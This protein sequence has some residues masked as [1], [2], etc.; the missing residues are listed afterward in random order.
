MLTKLS[1][2]LTTLLLTGLLNINAS[3]GQCTWRPQLYDGFEY[4]TAVPDLIPGTTIHTTPQ[5][6][7]VHSGA[8]SLYMNFVNSL[9]GGSLVYQR[10]IPVCANLPVRVS[11]WVTTT[12]AGAQ[13]NVKFQLLDANGISLYTTDSVP[14]PYAPLWT[15]YISG[16]VTP[17]TSTITFKMFTNT[18]GTAGGNDLSMDD[19]F[20]EQCNRLN[21]GADTTICNTQSVILN[22][23]NAYTSYLWSTGSTMQTITASTTSPGTSAS[24]YAVN[25][26][27]TNGCSYKDTIR[28]TFVPCAGIGELAGDNIIIS[29]NPAS[30]FIT[31]SSGNLFSSIAL[32]NTLGQTIKSFP[33][34]TQLNLSNIPKG[35]YFLRL[36]IH[37]NS[38]LL[39]KIVL[40]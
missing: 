29:P 26:T 8:K 39:R 11:A 21:L 18:P 25:A 3:L 13:C 1:T 27:D 24:D 30:D 12:F 14:A 20:V 28:V 34:A 33:G 22:A 23:G 9:P 17:T 2:L 16:S 7:A 38:N 40:E 35:I 10:T 5:S 15:K 32:I 31:I 36:E 4:S 37:D 6:F 19:F